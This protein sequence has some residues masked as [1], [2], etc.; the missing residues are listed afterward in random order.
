MALRS[1]IGAKSA[2]EKMVEGFY[3]RILIKEI[4][5]LAAITVSC[6]C[7]LGPAWSDK[8]REKSDEGTDVLIALDV[9]RSMLARDASPSRLEKAKDAVRLMAQSCSGS[10][11]GL[12]IFAGDAFLQ[13]PLT[14]DTGAFMM[15]LN[16]AS[17]DSLRYREQTWAGC[18]HWRG[19][20]IRKNALHPA[21]LLL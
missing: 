6:L 15:F 13:C 12:I 14:D 17:P 5:I 20:F 9:S 8:L 18:L 7:L 21:C 11:L 19:R 10:R 4:I 1:A 3:S 2:A 16:S